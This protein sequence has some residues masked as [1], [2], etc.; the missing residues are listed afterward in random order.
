MAKQAYTSRGAAPLDDQRFIA[1]MSLRK[2][3][4]L[5]MIFYKD[6]LL[7]WIIE[8]KDETLF[9][10]GEQFECPLT[11]EENPNGG[12]A[13]FDTGVDM[14]DF[15]PY[16]LAKY[17]PKLAVYN[18]VTSF[19][20][21]QS[22][23]GS[24]KITDIYDDKEKI[25]VESMKRTF[26]SQFWSGSGTGIQANG[27]NLL[28]PATAKSSQTVAVGEITPSAAKYWW[29]SQS[30][31][32]SGQAAASELEANMSNMQRTI[33]DQGGRVNIWGTDQTVVEIYERNQL[34]FIM[35]TKVTVG[36]NN[37][38]QIAFKG[39]PIVHSVD[40][41]SGELRAIDDRAIKM[42][43]DPMWWLS[44][45]EQKSIPNVPIKTMAQ[46]LAIFNFCR[47][48]PRWTGC[49]F[50]ISQNG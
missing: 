50:N 12:M 46:Y 39:A 1:T 42:A 17:F 20:Q 28:I 41:R 2:K 35:D 19:R 4:V 18:L 6:I 23:R 38:T 13:D 32:M 14:A 33:V 31:D 10:N 29:R 9:G 16:N 25:T 15:D 21:R 34:E 48:Q 24:G 45:T 26:I 43:V 27:I 22:N 47:V 7:N 49:I 5:D 11:S 3:E 30:T 8:R 36:D 40:A 44:W 37:Y